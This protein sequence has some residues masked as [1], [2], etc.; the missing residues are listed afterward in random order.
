MSFLE[1]VRWINKIDKRSS[2]NRLET[3]RDA[4]GEGKPQTLPVM[5][6]I[7]MLKPLNKAELRGDDLLDL[8]L[9]MAR[10]ALLSM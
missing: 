8:W 2:Y 10:V 7:F 4:K 1:A 9:L 6:Q 3:R 5:V